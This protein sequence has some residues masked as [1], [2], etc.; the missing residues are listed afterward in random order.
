[1]AQ[2]YTQIEWLRELQAELHGVFSSAMPQFR[3][4]FPEWKFS[5]GSAPWGQNTGANGYAVWFEGMLSR[6]RSSEVDTLALVVDISH[7]DT[8]PEIGADVC[9]GH[10]S[11]YVEAEWSPG[12]AVLN[13]NTRRQLFDSLPS[14]LEAMARALRQGQPPGHGMKS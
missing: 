9:W 2:D 1:M 3:S 11:G 13:D 4:A 12:R 10:P 6:A 14:L 5:L 7:V 8:T